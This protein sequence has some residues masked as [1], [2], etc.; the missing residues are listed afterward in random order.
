MNIGLT[1]SG[2]KYEIEEGKSGP[3]GKSITGEEKLHDTKYEIEEE[4]FEIKEEEYEIQERRNMKLKKRKQEM[5]LP[6]KK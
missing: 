5:P 3:R 1:V 6:V 2:Q 4:K